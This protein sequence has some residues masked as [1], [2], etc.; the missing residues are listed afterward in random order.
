[1]VLLQAML[2]MGKWWQRGA[3]RGEKVASRLK[4][5]SGKRGWRVVL[6]KTNEVSKFETKGPVFKTP[7]L[8]V[9][10]CV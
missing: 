10:R 2:A 9:E 6:I 7:A 3:E 8:V 4:S 5:T 1:M